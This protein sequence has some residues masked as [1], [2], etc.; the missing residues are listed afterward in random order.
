MSPAAGL[1][2]HVY[3]GKERAGSARAL[4]GMGVVLTTYGTLAQEAPAR[5]RAAAVRLGAR[6]VRAR[7]CVWWEGGWAG[8]REGYDKP[9]ESKTQKQSAAEVGPY[10][11]SWTRTDPL[12]GT[13]TCVRIYMCACELTRSGPVAAVQGGGEDSGGDEVGARGGVC[14]GMCAGCVCC[15]SVCA[16]VC[17]WDVCSAQ[18]GKGEMCA[19]SGADMGYGVSVPA[20]R[21]MH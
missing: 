7:V 4:A 6:Q 13:K 9:N 12:T 17:T 10:P 19:R 21:H 1:V 8:G 2:V 14:A 20:A 11:V 16:G 15:G 18:N 3:H 5:D